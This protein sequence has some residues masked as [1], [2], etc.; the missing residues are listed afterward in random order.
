M[1]PESQTSSSL[2]NPVERLL[3]TCCVLGSARCLFY[4][5]LYETL[6]FQVNPLVAME[7]VRSA[8]QWYHQSDSLGSG[9]DPAIPRQWLY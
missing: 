1:C 5:H 2:N 3:V 8:A 6:V 7:A 9:L 4:P